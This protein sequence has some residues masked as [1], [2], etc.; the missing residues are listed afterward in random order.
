MIDNTTP[1]PVETDT[2][3]DTAAQAP[4]RPV[5]ADAA[6]P[7]EVEALRKHSAK[8]R[9]E[10]KAAKDRAREAQEAREA[11]EADRD[12]AAAALR[13]QTLHA[14]RDHLLDEIAMPG[15][16]PGLLAVIE[17]TGYRFDLDDAGNPTILD[18]EGK[19]PVLV[20]AEVTY[21]GNPRSEPLR[22]NEGK[23]SERPARFEAGDV[24]R[25]LLSIDHPA[26]KAFD[27]LIVA[28]RASGSGASGS[29]GGFGGA[30]RG[31]SA[32][33]ERRIPSP[34]FGLK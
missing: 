11:A 4:E 6:D 10:A 3:P 14:P 16:A 23:R 1:D 12:A 32:N 7:N 25:I 27:A 29:H 30:A 24:R 20:D 26:A 22:R 17:A 13:A 9:A 18:P 33:C 34:Q 8:L 5:E 2:A 28:S 21:G 15:C 19:V 31:E